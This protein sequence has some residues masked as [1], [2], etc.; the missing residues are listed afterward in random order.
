M[1]KK[2]SM[3]SPINRRPGRCVI[4]CL[5]NG[6]IVYT[7]DQLPEKKKQEKKS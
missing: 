3:R 5:A 4:V 2:H 1:M 6:N 7:A